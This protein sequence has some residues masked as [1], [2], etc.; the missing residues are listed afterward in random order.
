[1]T[2]TI[3]H[4]ICAECVSSIYRRPSWDAG[5]W[6]HYGEAH[7]RAMPRKNGS[8]CPECNGR[9]VIT[10]PWTQAEDRCPTCTDSGSDRA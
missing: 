5:W 7:H 4:D 3:E 2:A 1:M 9:K 6:V 8:P 10:D